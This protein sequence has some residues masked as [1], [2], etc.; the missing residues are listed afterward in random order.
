MMS[1][2]ILTAKIVHIRNTAMRSK[3]KKQDR[4]LNLDRLF[5][6]SQKENMSSFKQNYA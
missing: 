2:R 4:K 6:N 1:R 5:I 3:A